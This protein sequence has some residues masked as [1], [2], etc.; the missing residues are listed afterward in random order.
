MKLWTAQQVAEFLQVAPRTVKE[1]YRNRPDFPRPCMIS[2]KKLRW[3]ADEIVSF[4]KSS[5]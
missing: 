4:V 1:K 2:T 5:R 3:D